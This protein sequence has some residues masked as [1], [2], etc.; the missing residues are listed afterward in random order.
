MDSR[1][2]EA[3]ALLDWIEELLR[4][5]VILTEDERVAVTLWVVHTHCFGAADTTP[6]LSITSAEKESGKTLL[7]EVLRLLVANPW[8]TG[9]TTVA[10]LVRK[11]D[12]DQPTLLL[13]E[14][15][16]AFHREREY[17]EALRGVL[18]TG[19]ERNGCA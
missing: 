5:W 18:N 13:D 1:S 19:Y 16:T 4:T 14:S 17:S 15:D 7:L 11:V 9:R 3:S 2:S 10:A 12:G 8:L 6:Y